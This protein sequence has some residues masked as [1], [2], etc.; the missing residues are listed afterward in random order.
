M[1]Y[2]VRCEVEFKYV[3]QYKLRD[4]CDV[5]VNKRAK[6]VDYIRKKGRGSFSFT[7]CINSIRSFFLHFRVPHILIDIK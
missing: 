6:T 5:G 3:R 1:V 2:I 4:V 7:S